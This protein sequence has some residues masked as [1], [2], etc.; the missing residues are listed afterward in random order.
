[1]K[2]HVIAFVACL[3]FLPA[4]L[5]FGQ[6]QTDKAVKPAASISAEADKKAQAEAKAAADKAKKEAKLKAEAEKK[7]KKAAEQ[8]AAAAAKAKTAAEKEAQ[9]KAEAQKKAQKEA[10]KKAVAEAK[11]KVEAEKKA[12]KDAEKQAAREAG[13]KAEAQKKAKEAAEKEAELKAAAEQKAREDAEQKAIAEAKAAAK[14]KEDAVKKAEAEAKAR[15]EAEARIEKAADL[16]MEKEVE[17]KENVAEAARKTAKQKS[18]EADKAAR[19]AK[20]LASDKKAAPAAKSKAQ[21]DAAAKELQ[22]KDAAAVV[23][24]MEAEA[25]KARNDLRTARQARVEAR[26]KA[27]LAAK[28]QKEAEQKAA[29]EAKIKAQEE[30]RAGKVEKQKADVATAADAT[31]AEPAGGWWK[32]NF[33]NAAKPEKAGKWK[34]SAGPMVRMIHGQSFKTYSYSQNYNIPAKAGDVFRR[35]EPAGDLSSYSDR[36]YDDGYVYKDDYTDL[37]GGTENWGGGQRNGNSVAFHY[38][39]RTYTEYSR[40]IENTVGET[41]NNFDR[42]IAPYI[43]LERSLYR[44]GWLDAGLH[45]DFYR[46][47]FS[48]DAQYSNFS[49]KQSWQNYVQ[50]DEDVYNVN[51][52]VINNIPDT[53]RG[54]GTVESGSYSYDAHNDIRQSLEMNLNTMSLGM[55]LSANLWRLSL[56]G[57][58]GPTFNFINMVASYN[59][60]LYAS[61]NNGSQQALQSW[62]DYQNYS[63]C[64]FGGFVQ[65]QLGLRIIDGFGVGIFGRYDWLETMSG[66]VGQSRYMI[67]PEGGSVGATANLS[68]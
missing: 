66:N 52:K 58:A 25:K 56:A 48:D 17:A 14:I 21:E 55:A 60:T 63:E 43:Q 57:V 4:V 11:A 22:A 51:G 42:E 47:S 34:L 31:I 3:M 32:R 13:L 19:K 1:M 50:Y 9:A 49:D 61:Q 16:K 26:K 24:A 8:E 12:R 5:V 68:F 44:C 35:Y 6:E 45:L 2:Y 64:K 36:N 59:E 7:A 62:S 67:N 39:G 65:A 10:E 15:A 23:P 53:R 54:A 37:D 41:H 33:D 46:A 29:I 28:A 38:I 40:S 27:E 18:A 30:A 20:E